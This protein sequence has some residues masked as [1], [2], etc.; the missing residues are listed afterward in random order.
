MPDTCCGRHGCSNG[1][2]VSRLARLEGR[3][4]QELSDIAASFQQAVVDVLIRKTMLAVARTGIQTVVLGGGVAANRTLRSLLEEECAR[5]NLKFMAAQWAYCTD[6][7]AMIAA[8]GYHKHKAG[9]WAGLD[10]DAYAHSG[11]SRSPGGAA[12]IAN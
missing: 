9:Q 1:G 2:P 11:D 7:A 6:N 5:R 4:Q 10:L 3:S 12:S 8:M